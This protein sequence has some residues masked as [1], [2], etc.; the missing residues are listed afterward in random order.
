[1][2]ALCV[3]RVTVCHGNDCHHS[4]S[5]FKNVLKLFI[6]F[7]LCQ[8]IVALRGLLC[9]CAWSCHSGGFSYCGVQA[10]GVRPSVLAAPRL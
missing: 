8:A 7:R 5:L 6:S 1:M 2:L 9:S 4:T 3:P 10:L